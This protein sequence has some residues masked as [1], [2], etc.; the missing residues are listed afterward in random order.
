LVLPGDGPAACNAANIY[1][2]P[3]VIGGIYDTCSYPEDPMRD[4]AHAPVWRNVL[5]PAA[6][7]STVREERVS[8]FKAALK[9][10]KE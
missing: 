1:A 10:L 6:T 3:L 5:I 8:V 9:F 2:P 7:H 4:L